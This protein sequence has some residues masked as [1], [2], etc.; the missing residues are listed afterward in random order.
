LKADEGGFAALGSPEETLDLLVAAAATHEAVGFALDVAATHFHHPDGYRIDGDVVS[1]SALIDRLEALV[2]RYPIVSI[3]D[4][5]AEDDWDGWRQLTDRLG[6][7]VQLIGDDLFTTNTD[8]LRHGIAEGVANAVL[9]KPNQA[10]TLSAAIEV[11]QVA[12]EAG[13]RT[14]ASARSGETED[15]FL[16]H[17]AVGVAAGQ[18]KVGSVAQSERLAKY[19]E[20]LRIEE[21]LGSR[22]VLGGS[23][24]ARRPPID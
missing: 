18:I 13:Y 23:G 1:S 20:L 5:L 3:E 8:R 11:V 14:V 24:V 12:R 17:F 19:N 16:A 15:A 2:D 4:G 9:V 10:G 21:E 7:R 22:A 6:D